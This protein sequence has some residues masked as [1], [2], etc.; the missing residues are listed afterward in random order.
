MAL[1]W[2]GDRTVIISFKVQ[3]ILVNI[4][5]YRDYRRCNLPTR[6]SPVRSAPVESLADLAGFSSRGSAPIRTHEEVATALKNVLLRILKSVSIV[7]AKR[8]SRF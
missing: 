5:A 3:D 6:P 4:F 1:L 8:I 2:S 7:L